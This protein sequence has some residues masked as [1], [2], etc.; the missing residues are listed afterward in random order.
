M[1]VQHSHCGIRFTDRSQISSLE[2][3]VPMIKS[4]M[5][6]MRDNCGTG[7]R[8][9]RFNGPMAYNMV[10]SLAEFHP[11]YRCIDETVLDNENLEAACVVSFGEIKKGGTFH[12]HPGYIDG[13]TQS[14]GFI[15]NANDRCDLRTEVFVNHGWDS[16]QLFEKVVTDRSYQTHVKMVTAKDNQWKGDIVVLSGDKLVA[17][18]RGVT[19]S[20]S[21]WFQGE[22]SNKP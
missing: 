12:T 3:E 18:I 8:T 6:E 5:A 11:D 15:M 1:T 13:L 4:R 9:F 10:Q 20:T 17:S 2:R 16:F 19:V 22:S 21:Q 7:G 14:G